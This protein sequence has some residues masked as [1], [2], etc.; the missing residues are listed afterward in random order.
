MVITA[1]GPAGDHPSQRHAGDVV[2]VRVNAEHSVVGNFTD[3]P[4]NNRTNLRRNHR[5]AADSGTGPPGP[6]SINDGH[7]R[8]PRPGILADHVPHEKEQ[9]L[10]LPH[11]V[12]FELLFPGQHP[13]HELL[14]K[15]PDSLR[16]PSPPGSGTARRIV[17]P[18]LPGPTPNNVPYTQGLVQPPAAA[19]RRTRSIH[20]TLP[21]STHHTCTTCTIGSM[22]RDRASR[23]TSTRCPPSVTTNTS[24][25][26]KDH[27]KRTLQK[28]AAHP[29]AYLTAAPKTPH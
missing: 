29:R 27:S 14:R 25:P 12:L 1:T 26:G 15:R 6:G 19:H 8:L 7:H 17:Q 10:K 9:T 20:G 18:V 23:K 21:K 28:N 5:A 24:N 3:V 4:H 2:P 13:G 22:P 11:M 16:L